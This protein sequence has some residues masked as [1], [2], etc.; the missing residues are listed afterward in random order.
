MLRT[1]HRMELIKKGCNLYI[2]WMQRY[3]SVDQEMRHLDSN[4]LNPT[5]NRIRDAQVRTV[6]GADGTQELVSTFP[7]VSL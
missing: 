4:L 1:G 3:I 2:I 6:T 7:K 5:S